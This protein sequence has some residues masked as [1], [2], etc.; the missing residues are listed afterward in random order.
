M[1]KRLFLLGAC[2]CA[3]FVIVFCPYAEPGMGA[4]ALTV[5]SPWL[6]MPRIKFQVLCEMLCSEE[7]LKSGG[8]IQIQ[9]DS[10][11]FL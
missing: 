1:C 5:A 11:M 4:A 3:L 2:P 8:F 10:D 6:S 9:L 7:S